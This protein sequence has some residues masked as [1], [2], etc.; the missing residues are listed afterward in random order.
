MNMEL[1][2]EVYKKGTSS[3][4]GYRLDYSV[5]YV[6]DAIRIITAQIKKLSEVVG[7]K[8]EKWIGNALIDVDTNRYVFSL[9]NS[10]V[11]SAE[12]RAIIF[13]DF[14]KKPIFLSFSSPFS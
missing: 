4:P 11:V 5:K 6:S 10:K 3:I 12:E 14:E 8:S 13:A 1:T 9:T 2:N 7:V